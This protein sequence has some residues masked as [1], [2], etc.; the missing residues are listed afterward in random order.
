MAQKG[1]LS[2]VPFVGA[3]LAELI[4]FNIPNQRVD[5]LEKFTVKLS[6]KIDDLPNEVKEIATEKL[7]EASSLP[8]VEKVLRDVIE[9]ESE[10]KLRYLASILKNGVTKNIDVIFRER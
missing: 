1:L 2:L 4:A 8:F 5:R 9:V 6:E 3:I 10:E 7:K